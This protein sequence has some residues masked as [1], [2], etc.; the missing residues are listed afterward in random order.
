VIRS[1]S[2]L[3]VG[4]AL[5]HHALNGLS[6]TLDVRHAQLGPVIVAEIKLAQVALQ[7]R[8]ADVVIHTIDAP[9][10]DREITLDQQVPEWAGLRSDAIAAV[11]L[12]IPAPRPEG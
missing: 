1:A 5:T 7:V 2:R 4:Q 10:E 8:R 9:L 3:F 12:W 6:G 11:P